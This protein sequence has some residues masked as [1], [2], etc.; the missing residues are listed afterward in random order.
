[1][2]IEQCQ[3]RNSAGSSCYAVSLSGLVE[4][5]VGSTWGCHKLAKVGCLINTIGCLTVTGAASQAFAGR[6]TIKHI[7]SFSAF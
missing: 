1:M 2:S 6:G 4:Y 7:H 5:V 3:P